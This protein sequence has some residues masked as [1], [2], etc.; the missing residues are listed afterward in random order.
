MALPS[1]SVRPVR[2]NSY[3]YRRAR[4]RFR[5]RPLLAVAGLALIVTLVVRL[6]PTPLPPDHP[7]DDTRLSLGGDPGAAAGDGPGQAGQRAGT[8]ATEPTAPPPLGRDARSA[9]L[10]L[11]TRDEAPGGSGERPSTQGAA[12]ASPASPPVDPGTATPPGGS[13]R[14]RTASGG[15]SRTTGAGTPPSG[16]PE[17]R[18][19]SREVQRELDRVRQGLDEIARNRPVDGRRTLSLALRSGRLPAEDAA[20]VRARLA[21]LN[22]RLV[23]SGELLEGDPYAIAYV[24]ERGDALSALPRK[25]GV[26]TDWRFIQRVNGIR[27][28]SAVA[29]GR[30]LKV[31]TGPFHAVVDKTAYR[32][33]LWLGDELDPVFV[34]SFD[35]GLGAEDGT[36][37]GR[38]R[39][40]PGSKLINPEWVNPRTRERFLP[41]D[42]KNPIGE[43]WI[44][45]VGDEP[46]LAN[47]QGYGLHGTIEPDSIGTAS[48]MGCIRM[49]A[50]D[51]ALIWEVLVSPS[52][53]I[54][55]RRRADG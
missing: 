17:A 39:V 10:A 46:H 37:E 16:V 53:A 55:I 6:W 30:R 34:R 52:S 44:G 45:L 22:E 38:F 50:D 31:V 15:P 5:G 43:H 42:P 33:D 49:H 18:E 29:A 8:T 40:R 7:E 4:P 25:L 47:V 28:P 2:R 35:V 14:E 9:M 54:S 13:P 11:P 41:D 1:Q 20:R 36:P 32:L 19:I 24:V 48:S 21:E 12:D 51:I 27:S 23:F 3:T 26:Q